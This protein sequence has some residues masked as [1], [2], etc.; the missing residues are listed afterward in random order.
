MFAVKKARVDPLRWFC[1]LGP[2]P[3]YPEIAHIEKG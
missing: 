3:F 2:P 1:F